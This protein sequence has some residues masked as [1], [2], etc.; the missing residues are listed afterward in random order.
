MYYRYIVSFAVIFFLYLFILLLYAKSWY[1][2]LIFFFAVTNTLFK[3]SQIMFSL[4][5]HPRIFFPPIFYELIM[6]WGENVHL[7]WHLSFIPMFRLRVHLSFIFFFFSFLLYFCCGKKEIKAITLWHKICIEY[8][9][10][11]Y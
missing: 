9:Y 10:L 5:S 8:N 6:Q 11:L 7:L 3:W 1:L 4:F 2:F